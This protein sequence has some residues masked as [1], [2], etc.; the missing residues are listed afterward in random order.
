MS[1]GSGSTGRWWLI[2]ASIGVVLAAACGGGGSEASDDAPADQEAGPPY[3]VGRV[4]LELLDVSRTTQADALRNLPE[5][6]ERTIPTVVLYPEAEGPFPLIVFAHGHTRAGAEYV[7][8]VSDWVAQGYVVAL[9]SFPLSSGPEAISPVSY[10]DVVNQPGDISF[11][12]RELTER[13]NA[14]EPGSEEDN[15]LAHRIDTEHVG[16]VGHSLGAITALGLRNNTCC[17]DP[18]VDAVVAVAGMTLPFPG[19]PID[20]DGA[21]LLLIHSKADPTVP[22]AGSESVFVEALP[23]LSF[24]E[25]AEGGHDEILDGG[26]AQAALTRH[27]ILAFFDDQLRGAAATWQDL[28]A[29]VEESGLATF[30]STASRD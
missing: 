29:K 11:V 4:D 3:E 28:P 9:P 24:L 10:A 30:Q 21:P 26:G 18:N 14:E 13:S 15:P 6:A 2:V 19:D 7:E 8:L 17:T 23:P 22:A 27:A 5:Q 12:V 25:F 20:S 1:T 16:V